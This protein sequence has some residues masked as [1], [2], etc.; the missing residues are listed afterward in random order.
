MKDPF[1]TLSELSLPVNPLNPHADIHAALHAIVR[2]LVDHRAAIREIGLQVLDLADAAKA[3]RH[4]LD[5]L[6]ASQLEEHWPDEVD[7]DIADL[8]RDLTRLATQ[9]L[10]PDRIYD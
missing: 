8:R 5:Q 3:T 6:K 10:E 2:I 7:S 4:D 9:Q 1:V